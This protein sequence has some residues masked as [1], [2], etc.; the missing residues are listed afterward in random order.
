MTRKKQKITQFDEDQFNFV[1]E[2]C[3]VNNL[4]FKG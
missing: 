1:Y 3:K 2:A 4:N